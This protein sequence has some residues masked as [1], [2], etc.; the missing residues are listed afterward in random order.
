MELGSE[1]VAN[2]NLDTK[3]PLP[4]TPPFPTVLDIEYKAP[5]LTGGLT[6]AFINLNTR[7][8]AAQNRVD[9][10]EKPTDGYVLLGLS[11][12][13]DINIKKQHISMLFNIQNMLNTEY[14]NHLSRYRWLNLPEQGRNISISLV[15][16]FK[17][18]KTGD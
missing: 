10:N 16:P 14:M 7:F 6:N 15:Y 12:G 11:L 4:F 13:T 2:Y 1:Y 8:T 5:E 3:L 17:I 18:Q 9:R